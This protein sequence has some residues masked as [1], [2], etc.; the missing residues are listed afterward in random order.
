M[1]VFEIKIRS[2]EIKDGKSIF[3]WRNDVHSKNMSFDHADLSFEQHMIWL[4]ESLLNSY[5]KF[6]IGEMNDKKIG[7]CRFDYYKTGDYCVVSINMNPEF[8]GQGLGKKFLSQ[9]V[10]DYLNFRECTLIAKIKPQNKASINS[11]IFAGFEYINT[12]ETFLTMERSHMDFKLKEVEL[13]DAPILFELLKSRTYSISH[14]KLPSQYEH[15]AF[16]KSKPYR[17]WAIV[18][19]GKKV[20]G[21]FYIQYDNSIG[22][23]LLKPRKT[24]V[25]IIL[26]HIKRNFEPEKE[27]K[28]KIPSYYYVNIAHGDE[29]LREILLELNSVPIQISFKI[30]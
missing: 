21:S 12:N 28:S 17:F 16:V 19:E 5:K 24:L 8:R 1:A 2:A 27:V 7:V 10:E 23:N 14:Q 29:E 4:S 6:Y 9:C 30:K 11:F 20:V 26:N 15:L 18:Y 13:E 3:D 25:E 22:L